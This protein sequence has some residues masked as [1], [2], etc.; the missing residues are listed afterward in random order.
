L[1][2]LTKK[3]PL[4]EEDLAAL[5]KK[6]LKKK[7]LK[8]K[9]RKK[10]LQE[11]RKIRDQR[12]KQRENL[13]IQMDMWREQCHTKDRLTFEKEAQLKEIEE[14]L[15]K[16]QK[17]R[18][19]FRK[20]KQLYKSIQKLRDLRKEK[21]KLKGHFFPK[22]D[23]QFEK[24]IKEIENLVHTELRKI[25]RKIEEK[26]DDMNKLKLGDLS[27]GGSADSFYNKSQRSLPDLIEIRREWD[28]FVVE[29]GTPGA[30]IIPLGD[31]AP[32]PP[33]NAIWAT[34]LNTKF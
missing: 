4:S 11:L 6:K 2:I 19:K 28:K 14:E 10:H 25:E 32:S 30:S 15:T 12:L 23:R 3:K 34:A 7:E 9:W 31:I 22:E 13:H 24:Q 8:R 27:V 1:S 26:T 20:L 29:S 17:D 18:Q 16:H 33:A 5:Q 21:A